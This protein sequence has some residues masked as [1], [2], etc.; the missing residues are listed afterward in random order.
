MEALL[1]IALVVSF[2]YAFALVS[3]LAVD[4]VTGR[5]K[6][7]YGIAHKKSDSNALVPRQDES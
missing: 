3:T 7:L 4:L 1:V 5:F 2:L 6:R